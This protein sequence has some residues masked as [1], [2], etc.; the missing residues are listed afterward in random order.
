M[1]IPTS[2]RHRLRSGRLPGGSEAVWIFRR[3]VV[4]PSH[5]LQ[6]FADDVFLRGDNVAPEAVADHAMDAIRNARLAL[7][8]R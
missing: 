3:A 8:A 1:S 4:E 7:N 2:A 6:L 5:F